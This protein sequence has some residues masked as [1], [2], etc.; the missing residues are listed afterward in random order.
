MKRFIRSLLPGAPSGVRGVASAVAQFQ[1]FQ[2]ELKAE[3]FDVYRSLRALN[4][5]PYLFYLQWEDTALLGSSPETMVRV[6][7]RTAMVRPIA[8]TRRRGED[9]AEDEAQHVARVEPRIGNDGREEVPQGSGP[10]PP[11]S[12][13][14]KTGMAGDGLRLHGGCGGDRR[15]KGPCRLGQLESQLRVSPQGYRQRDTNRTNQ[16]P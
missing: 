15:T 2:T 14:T 12:P 16:R 10:S 13:A 5:S 7:D 9:A 1:R 4:P 3:P 6:E 8:G 11:S